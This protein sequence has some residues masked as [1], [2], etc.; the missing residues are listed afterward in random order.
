ME[1]DLLAN[2][3]DGEGSAFWL[4]T[5]GHVR[6][7]VVSGEANGRIRYVPNP[8]Y[9]GTDQFT[10]AIRN[11][12]G[13]QAAAT[14]RI[15]INPV[16]DAPN[17]APVNE[18]TGAVGDRISLLLQ[19]FDVDDDLLSYS[20]EGLPP[21]L[22]LDSATGEISG[23]LWQGGEYAATVTASDGEASAHQSFRW[24]VDAPGGQANWTAIFLPLVSRAEP[25][26]DLVGEIRLEPDHSDF[27][28]GETVTILVTIANRGSVQSGG[29]WVDLHINPAQPPQG[30]P[31]PWNKNC[32]LTPCY[33]VTWYVATLPAGTE[34]ELSSRTPLVGY[35]I[36]NG[37]FAP[38]TT[39]LYLVVDSW[40]GA[41][42]AVR[43]SDES[44]NGASLHGLSVSGAAARGDEVFPDLPP[45]PLPLPT[46]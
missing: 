37:S 17:L 28:A 4:A 40:S 22:F 34:I 45:R 10:Y 20:A 42:G 2:D 14:V 39:D 15:T 31:A 19:A 5:I 25:L 46:E 11:S 38:G 1:L 24:V 26:P 8:H 6:S 21:G 44:N 7:G 3:S 32:G 27:M 33:G 29:F 36:W 18:Q 41:A 13:G 23:V 12:G 16:N 35:S 30:S 43:E 9:H